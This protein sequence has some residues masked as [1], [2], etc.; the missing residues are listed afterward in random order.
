[1]QL[2]PAS[3]PE[4]PFQV[5]PEQFIAFCDGLEAAGMEEYARRGRMVARELAE[6]R[7]RVETLAAALGRMRE[8]RDRWRD[9][10]W[11]EAHGQPWPK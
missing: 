11:R 6:S 8:E 5:N 1:M 7:R 2:V 4:S 10:R 9:G 3:V